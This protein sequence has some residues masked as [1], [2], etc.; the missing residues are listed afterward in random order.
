MAKASFIFGVILE[1]LGGGS[2]PSLAFEAFP[3]VL[4]ARRIGREMY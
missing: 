4:V 3:D 1:L 2:Q